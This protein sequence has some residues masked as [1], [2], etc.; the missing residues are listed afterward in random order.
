MDGEPPVPKSPS[1]ALMSTATVSLL[2]SLNLENVIAVMPGHGSVVLDTLAVVPGAFRGVLPLAPPPAHVLIPCAGCCSGSTIVRR[3]K[4]ESVSLSGYDAEPDR[5]ARE[6]SHL[7][8]RDVLARMEAV[9]TQPR[10][11]DGK[12]SRKFMIIYNPHSGKNKAGKVRCLLQ[13]RRVAGICSHP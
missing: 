13:L 2:G 1:S 6:L 9:G 3:H 12:L 8:V 4:K 10:F 11:V 5:V 7:L